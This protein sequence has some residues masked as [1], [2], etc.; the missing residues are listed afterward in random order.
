MAGLE[1][2]LVLE[3][4]RRRPGGRIR[5]TSTL[6]KTPQRCERAKSSGEE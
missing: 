4:C 3:T 1:V 6:A 5:E 2:E